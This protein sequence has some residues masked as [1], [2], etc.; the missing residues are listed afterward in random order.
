MAT[1]KASVLNAST[2]TETFEGIY[3]ST[4][5][6]ANVLTLEGWIQAFELW[7]ES[8]ISKNAFASVL[9]E[10]GYFERTSTV[11]QN[12]GHIAWAI[13][14][15][16]CETEDIRADY[17][18]MNEIREERYGKKSD[19]PAPK[20]AKAKVKFN[21]KTEASKYTRAEILEMLAVKG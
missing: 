2:I 21:A 16:G 3:R 6:K 10:G 19:A 4:F 15:N 7:E 20:K 18:G 11:N 8:G 1:I 9:V 13:E 17:S 12:F 5:H 14:E